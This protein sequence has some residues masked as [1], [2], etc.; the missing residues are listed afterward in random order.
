M[1]VA[2]KPL[3]LMCLQNLITNQQKRDRYTSLQYNT[4]TNSTSSK[5]WRDK[6]DKYLFK[7]THLLISAIN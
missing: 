6:S 3:S 4:E 1:L 7:S 2:L 5:E